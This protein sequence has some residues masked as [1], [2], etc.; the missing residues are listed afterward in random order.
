MKKN[1]APSPCS[2]GTHAGLRYPLPP[3]GDHAPRP[4]SGLGE[5]GRRMTT[6]AHDP[7]S[8]AD[9]GKGYGGQAPG[10][11]RVDHGM[12]IIASCATRTGQAK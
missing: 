2:S 6:R 4:S 11:R 3:A 5:N 1:G 9:R 8:D 7:S 10:H 12:S